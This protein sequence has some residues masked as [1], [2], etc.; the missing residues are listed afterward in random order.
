[1]P[2]GLV[3][4]EGL[5]HLGLLAGEFHC[6]WPID[7]TVIFTSLHTDIYIQVVP[8]TSQE[9][10]GDES[11][12]VTET[13]SPTLGFINMDPSMTLL[14]MAMRLAR[15]CKPNRKDGIFSFV[16]LFITICELSVCKRRPSG[17]G[18]P[19]TN[20]ISVGN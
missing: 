14:L 13:G 5:L 9:N 6:S 18:T 4:L 10:Q 15:L 11:R 20:M 7:T 3:N 16:F 8:K 2:C 12:L 19:N 17:P 1:M